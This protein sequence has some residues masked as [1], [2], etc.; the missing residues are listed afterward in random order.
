M[1]WLSFLLL[2]ACNS[3]EVKIYDGNPIVTETAGTKKINGISMIAAPHRIDS[4]EFSL[5][6]NVNANYV[7]LL[8]F[9]FVRNGEPHVYYNTGHQWW[10]ESPAGIAASIKLAHQNGLQ[11]VIKPQ[12][13]MH[14]G[15]T[16]DLMFAS[17]D[18]WK[19]FEQS[20]TNYIFQLL[21]LA[22][23]LH[24]E[25]FCL[26]NELD[27]FVMQRTAYWS[28]LIDTARTVFHGKLVYAENWDC[29][30]KFPLWSK[31]DYIGTNAY[32]P[33]SD[34]KTPTTDELIGKWKIYS[35]QLQKYSQR[36]SKPILFTEYGYRS[37]D[38]ATEEPWDSYHSAAS[39][40]EAQKNAYEAFYKT[41]WNQEW[42]AGGF[43]W[44]WL[45]S[46]SSAD[47]P[48][49][50]DYTPQGKPAMEVLK[51]WYGENSK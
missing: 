26:G 15:F 14:N 28:H 1:F 39:N 10:G 5:F 9:A 30:D 46:N 44:K 17:D 51:K 48:V 23:S 12:I 31:L 19:K 42:C 47:V 6:R 22:D 40:Y 13:W 8:P 21:P 43:S 35:E 36:F 25:M 18:E 20:Y 24:A 45:D 7:C 29:Y 34:S 41:F 11:V 2:I 32:F 16:G 27:S 50:I 38:F 37:I 33:L 4:S 49:E 3:S